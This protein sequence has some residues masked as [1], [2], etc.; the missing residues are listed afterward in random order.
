[1]GGIRPQRQTQN[2]IFWGSRQPGKVLR[3]HHEACTLFFLPCRS[4]TGYWLGDSTADRPGPP[5]ETLHA[6]SLSSKDM[7]ATVEKPR[8]DS[9]AH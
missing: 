2:A 9:C 1:M 4:A 8:V 7:E 5:S 3:G 6:P